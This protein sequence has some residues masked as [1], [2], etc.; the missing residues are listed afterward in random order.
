MTEDHH[1][2]DRQLETIGEDD[3]DDN[4][5]VPT[6]M[7]VTAGLRGK[8]VR[9]G[10]DTGSVRTLL[11][12]NIFNQINADLV[13][14]LQPHGT[15]FSA[16]N[17]SRIECI[18]CIKLPVMFYGVDRNYRATVLF[19]VIRGLGVEGLLGLDEIT[20]HGFNLNAA[21][22]TCFQTKAGEMVI[23][24]VYREDRSIRRVTIHDNV[25][26]PPHSQCDIQGKVADVIEEEQGEGIITPRTD[27]W[28]CGIRASRTLTTAQPVTL[29]QVANFSDQS[30]GLSK[31]EEFGTFHYITGT[32][33]MISTVVQEEYGECL[34][35]DEDMDEKLP[36]EDFET[37]KL[38]E[39]D[40]GLR[41][42]DLNETQKQQVRSQLEK[43]KGVFQ[44]DGSPVSFT[45]RTKHKIVLKPGAAPIKH[46]S[47]K[48]SDEQNKFIEE[49]VNK[50][51]K[52]DIVQ[53]S[54]SNWSSRIV[55]AWEERKQRWRLCVDY[56]AVNCLSAAPLAYPLPNIEEL[57]DQF[58]GQVY[59]HTLDLFQG[60]HQVQL[61]EG[62]REITAFATRYGL[63]EFKRMP[64]GLHSCP[65]T[66]Q[67]LMQEV[68]GDLCWKSAIVYIDDLIIFGRTY[69][70]AFERL[71]RVLEKLAAA[72]LRL[73]ASKCRLFQKSVEFLG[74]IVSNEG[75]KTCRHI[76]DAVLNFPTPRNVKEVQRLLGI[77]NYYRTFIK[78]HS[79]ILSPIINLTRKGVPFQWTED[80]QT[81]FETIKERLTT[82]P[83]RNYFDPRLPTVLTT[84]A[85]GKGIGSTVSQVDRTGKMRLIAYGSKTLKQTEVIWS[86]TEKELYAIT[87]FI[88]KFRHY[89][90]NP[91][92]VF[93]DHHSLRYVSTLRDSSLKIARWL[94]FL[95]QYKFEV[96]HRPGDSREMLVADILSRLMCDREP[97]SMI[98][99]RM[100]KPVFRLHQ[101]IGSPILISWFALESPTANDFDLVTTEEGNDK[102]NEERRGLQLG[103]RLRRQQR[104]VDKE[105]RGTEENFNCRY[106]SAEEVEYLD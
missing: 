37:K 54:T 49:E 69:E 44:W 85:S 70:E 41:E 60:Y 75:I 103:V 24:S 93:S 95:M 34:K 53:A 72:K 40:F 9:L 58:R 52:Q 42:T 5:K 48:F 55:L 71:M 66:Y 26:L 51:I 3:Y 30:I 63:F 25:I 92:I 81:A 105:M 101:G 83:V 29:T 65:T 82:P 43:V 68:L 88:K 28:R 91:F 4:V 46:K 1:R 73:R 17:G 64:F 16:V 89:L 7:Y 35:E 57:L 33:V 104:E 13:Y 11:S 96:H 8:E 59:F 87:F 79:Q 56:R 61:E 6:Y 67:R 15:Q 20:R 97:D 21:D 98:A 10:F 99:H 36:Y 62:S 45:H 31:G 50:L 39:V 38:E 106:V 100:E 80:C 77:A 27:I 94:N 102:Q 47:R 76:V 18:G 78:S 19:Y 22:G 90:A 23:N 14:Q 86:T 2:I 12:E 74:F 84:D 32:P